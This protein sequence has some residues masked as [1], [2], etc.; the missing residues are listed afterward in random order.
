MPERKTP[1]R[2]PAKT[3]TLNRWDDDLDKGLM[4]SIQY[5]CSEAGLKIPWA[6]VAEIMGPTFT[7][8]AIV[9]HL[10][11]LRNL[12][13]A[14][15]I[16]VPPSVK[17]G[18]VTKSPSK[19]YGSAA[20]SRIKLEPIEPLFPNGTS[21]TTIKEEEDTEPALSVYHR[22]K[23][24]GSKVKEAVNDDTEL[25]DSTQT[26]AADEEQA[27]SSVKSRA[28]AKPK[29]R[30][31][32]RG[33]MSDEDDEE[34]IPE[35]YDSESEYSVPKKRRRTAAKSRRRT[36]A[37]KGPAAAA[38]LT[39]SESEVTLPV[40]VQ[41]EQ[42]DDNVAIKIEEEESGPA[43]R[44]R[45]VKRDYSQMAEPSSEEIN[46]EEEQ[47]E[48]T[49]N[50]VDDV[51]E[52]QAEEGA[53][54]AVDVDDGSE[55]EKADTEVDAVENDAEVV[56]EAD[57]DFA[58]TGDTAMT[59]AEAQDHTDAPMQSA[60]VNTAYGQLKVDT[61]LASIM[62]QQYSPVTTGY[63]NSFGRVDYLNSGN[64]FS[65][66]QFAFNNNPMMNFMPQAN[67]YNRHLS[68]LSSYSPAA[69]SSTN[70]SMNTGFGVGFS[71]LPAMSNDN[72]LSSFNFGNDGS[73]GMVNEQN[74]ANGMLD[75]DV[76]FTQD[77]DYGV[78]A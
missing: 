39:E 53:T 8:G 42:D 18:M 15:G 21:S 45:G 4:L 2:S 75:G 43:T 35:L 68:S 46:G 31:R 66:N 72:F 34:P 41:G 28:R 20:N 12:M 9:Q 23:S 24:A 1:R 47:Q 7:D 59:Q 73:G 33:N 51:R 55:S 54:E 50:T 26:E 37:S 48:E 69:D 40:R 57:N 63:G 67:G 77:G 29:S 30:N 3:R 14:A 32:R 62:N 52:D 56:G 13:M 71:G 10:A 49:L 61:D 25:P 70:S 78:D 5:A 6:R 60:K 11:K 64:P 27:R 44:T 76:F 19:I 17:R 74:P 58:D 36:P 38:A 65:G 22:T 16:P